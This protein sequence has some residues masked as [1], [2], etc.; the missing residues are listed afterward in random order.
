[1][2]ANDTFRML[3]INH[4]IEFT[5]TTV[6]C[7]CIVWHCKVWSFLFANVTFTPLDINHAIEF[8]TST[9]ICNCIVWHSKVWLFLF[10]NVT[11]T[12]HPFACI[13]FLVYG[14][15]SFYL[16]LF[17][18]PKFENILTSF[19]EHINDLFNLYVNKTI[20]FVRQFASCLTIKNEKKWHICTLEK[21]KK[22]FYSQTDPDYSKKD[23]S[24]SSSPIVITWSILILLAKWSIHSTYIIMFQSFDTRN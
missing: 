10:A 2:F 6:I 1:L 21:I 15:I 3:D 16:F 19:W 9:V 7:N 22:I 11:F 18:L 14:S 24:A 12:R 17:I 20:T 13:A 4:A 8:T 23:R 5:T